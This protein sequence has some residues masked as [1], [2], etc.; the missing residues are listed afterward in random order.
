MTVEDN[1]FNSETAIYFLFL[2]YFYYFWFTVESSADPFRVCVQ[3]A[4]PS[5]IRYGTFRSVD[6]VFYLMVQGF[7][8]RDLAQAAPDG[9]N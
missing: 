6:L 5:D 2:F 8:S 4:V 3:S 9:S 7:T 1:A